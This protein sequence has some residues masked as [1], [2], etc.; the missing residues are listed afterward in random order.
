MPS[1][2]NPVWL[3]SVVWPSD[4]D[5]CCRASAVASLSSEASKHRDMLVIRGLETYKNL[6]NK[7]LRLMRYALT[8]PAG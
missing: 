6:P 4:V 8:S 3:Q 7:S 2:V 5:V 1:S